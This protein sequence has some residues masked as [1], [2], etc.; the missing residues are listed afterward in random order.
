MASTFESLPIEG[1]ETLQLPPG[2]YL[3]T[4]DYDHDL[5]AADIWMQW[6]YF[7]N[8]P[9]FGGGSCSR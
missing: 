1:Q 3:P 5:V 8:H 4:D 2:L 7:G 6:H 9:M